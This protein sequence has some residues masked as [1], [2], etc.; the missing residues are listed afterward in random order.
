M[1]KQS[2]DT[3]R[4]IENPMIT[5]DYIINE[6][7]GKYFDRKSAGIKP[8][9]LA[10]PISAFANAE[11]GVVVIGVTDSTR[12]I[13][14]INSCGAD[15]INAFLSAAK[16]FCKPMPV[17]KEEFLNVINSKGEKDRLILLHI[18][19]STD[20]IIRTTSDSTFLRIGD[21]TKE[22]KGDDLRNLEYSKS[23]RQYEDECNMDAQ[24]SDMDAN[25]LDEY[26]THI[27]ATDLSDEQILSARGFIKT[28][29]GT[30]YL[31]NAA[32]LL[33]AKNIN[34]FYPNCRIRFV[35]YDG[36]SEKVGTEINVIKDMNFESS[37][38]TIIDE[39]KKYI[40]D[41]LREFTALDQQTGKFKNVPEYPEFAWQ[42]G[43]V[44]AVTHREYSMAGSYIKV[45]MFDDRLEIQSPGKL[46]DIVTV[47]NIKETRYSRNPR[48]AR[49]LTE[50]G[51]VRELNEGVKRIYSDME[52][53]FLDEPIYT[54]PSNT[55]KLVLKNNI[56]MRMI[57]QS[58]KTKHDIGE[59]IWA[60]CDDLEKQI[61]TYMGSHRL[62]TRAELE[63][64]TGK[65]GR[66]ITIRLNKMINA[67][68][69]KRNG[70]KNDP[71]QTYEIV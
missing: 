10:K 4:S 7:E 33:F 18:Y 70:T 37:I 14:G 40:S 1:I 26:K 71:K 56:V 39:A 16:D 34:R 60:S 57:R 67:N 53:F 3:L 29:K 23:T 21:K 20:Q 64:Y 36:I 44:N 12:T 11:G 61:L 65:A 25:L 54:E 51:W 42:E 32:V 59:T 47:E 17:C 41:Q 58:D 6:P 15:R 35:R 28:I 8:S 66:T 30:D 27:G 24:I 31:T 9:D 5:L 63:E 48:I 13:E 68:I 62:A 52:N 45:S 19:A 55:V 38:L 46:P 50:F 49:V 69:I 22:L 43:I 2:N